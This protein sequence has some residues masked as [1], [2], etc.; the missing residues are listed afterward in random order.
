MTAAARLP[1]DPDM[2]KLIACPACSVHVKRSDATCPHCG[3]RV[4]DVHGR[5]SRTAGALLMGLSLTACGDKD[6]DETTAHAS[7]TEMSSSASS[8]SSSSSSSSTSSTSTSTSTSTDATGQPAYGV[9]ATTSGT[10]ASTTAGTGTTTESDSSSSG[11]AP[12]YGVPAS[13]GFPEP[14]TG[15]TGP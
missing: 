5:I 1:Y 3:A 2:P 11:P 13:T 14:E 6:P 15:T 7:D 9:P 12:A 10:T 8:S 4:R